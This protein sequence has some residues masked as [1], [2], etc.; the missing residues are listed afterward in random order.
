MINMGV[1][2][3]I[4]TN[5]MFVIMT[6]CFAILPFVGRKNL[7]F[8]V[9]IPKAAYIS[10]PVKRARRRFL[11]WA[12]AIGAAAMM[13]SILGGR[14]MDE[15]AAVGLFTALIMLQL[16]GY[17]VLYY[18]TYRRMKRLKAE[19]GW[20]QDAQEIMIAD[21]RF[22][23]SNKTAC[24]PHWFWLDAVIIAISAALGIVFYDRVPDQVPL[25]MNM[26][27]EYVTFAQKSVVSVFFPV[28]MQILMLGVF[29]FVYYTFKRTPPVIDADD[30]EK[31]ARQNAIFRYRWS[32]FTV[33][34]G[35]CMM[36]VFGSLML[37]N[38]NAL[39]LEAVFYIAMTI[40]GL[41]I[42]YAI[43]LSVT[44]GQSGSRVRTTVSLDGTTINRDDDR[45]WVAGSFY[46]N[47]EDPAM[48]VEKRFGIGT[49]VNFGNTK[50]IVLFVGIMA[51]IIGAAIL[52]NVLL[53]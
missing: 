51:V 8:G 14:A 33:F 39:P 45:Y 52:S 16:I 30:A 23:E 26:A 11:I 34:G 22:F 44:T 38:I 2:S 29:A 53:K 48:F 10:Q 18:V 12:I 47:K 6:V 17:G 28:F 46:Y 21:T 7:A 41:I 13:G 1:F 36:L 31:S 50:A 19:E 25:Q 20:Q 4:S 49:T 43:V 9:S 5:M 42:V 37:V 35:F 24:S 27:G 32:L 3:E 15:P 40:V